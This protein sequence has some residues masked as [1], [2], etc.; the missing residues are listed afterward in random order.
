MIALDAGC[1]RSG[2]ADGMR[3]IGGL[4]D[5][6]EANHVFHDQYR[7]TALE[8][9]AIDDQDSV[10]GT[11]LSIGAHRALGFKRQRIFVDAT[12]GRLEI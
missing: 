4:Y 9:L 3:V 8:P 5:M 2:V 7:G 12:K 10:Y 1:A 11:R 6:S